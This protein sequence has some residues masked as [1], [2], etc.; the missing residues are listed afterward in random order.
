[1]IL[2]AR[3][4]YGKPITDTATYT[5][6]AVGG[7]KTLGT[8]GRNFGK[9]ADNLAEGVGKST[10]TVDIT[11]RQAIK[12]QEISVNFY[13]DSDSY[14]AIG[15]DTFDGKAIWAVKQEKLPENAADNFVINTENT[16]ETIDYTPFNRSFGGTTPLEGSYLATKANATR[17]ELAILDECGN[18]MTR[19]GYGYIPPKE[20]FY[21][22]KAAAKTSED[23][24]QTLPGGADQILVKK[25]APVHQWTETVIDKESGKKYSIE[26]FKKAFPNEVEKRK[27]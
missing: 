17:E 20:K 6:G 21:Y 8:V 23:K 2:Y 11:K 19:E 27:K 12:E 14:T 1:M 16:F 25:D 10:K 18:T 26:E 4:I 24:T 7:V 3:A 15:Q 22:G 13:R 5:A 9:S